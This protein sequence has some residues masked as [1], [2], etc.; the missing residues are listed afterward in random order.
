LP[1]VYAVGSGL[2]FA[3]LMGWAR[4]AMRARGSDSHLTTTIEILSSALYAG[5]AVYLLRTLS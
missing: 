5:V 3:I 4:R 1:I 2:L